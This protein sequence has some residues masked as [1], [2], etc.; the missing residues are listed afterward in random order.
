MLDLA[1][2]DGDNHPS[3]VTT[4]GPPALGCSG[5]RSQASRGRC[6]P[7]FPSSCFGT[8]VGAKWPDPRILAASGGVHV[9]AK[10]PNPRILAASGGVRVG[11]KCRATRTLGPPPSGL[12]ARPWDVP[13]FRSLAPAPFAVTLWRIFHSDLPT[14]RVAVARFPWRPP[15]PPRARRAQRAGPSRPA[16]TGVPSRGCKLY[17]CPRI[18]PDRPSEV[19]RQQG[20][21]G[22]G[23]RA[24][25]GR[26][27]DSR[28]GL[29]ARPNTPPR[30]RW[31]GGRH[32]A[33]PRVANLEQARRS[34]VQAGLT[35]PARVVGWRLV[36]PPPA[37]WHRRDGCGN[38]CHGLCQC[39]A[40]VGAPSSRW[41]TCG[42]VHAGEN[43]PSAEPEKGH[44]QCP[45]HTSTVPP[46]RQR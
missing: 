28:R 40:R 3:A 30:R 42:I 22:R 16:L 25:R 37:G 6:F 44:G 15:R 29:G 43:V 23:L 39:R 17:G 41:R 24:K 33:I 13:A 14:G 35:R 20:R 31:G 8:R 7:W 38:V 10:W 27:R 21:A 4:I 26:S 46:C 45:W 2:V 32:A 34:F 11:D 19:K 12:R 5:R 1:D 18:M 36:R 9:G